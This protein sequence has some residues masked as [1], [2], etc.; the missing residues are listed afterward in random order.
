MTVRQAWRWLGSRPVSFAVMGAWALLLLMWLA[1]FE[2]SG[3][4]ETQIEAI[5]TEWLPFRVA[6]AALLL[7]TLACTVERIRR[8]V[9]R[10][11]RPVP[12]A[13]ALERRTPLGHIVGEDLVR[14]AGRLSQAGYRVKVA[15]HALVGVL[16]SWAPLGGSALHVALL[17]AAVGIGLHAW[18]A[19]EVDF[20]AIEG[21][22]LAP[23]V[24]TPV[25]ETQLRK[26]VADARLGTI[27]PA[28]YEDVLL[29][30]SLE[31]TLERADGRADDLSLARPLWLDPF[32]YLSVVD[33]GY[34][35]HFTVV[36]E[37]GEVLDDVV[38]AMSLFPPGNADRASLSGSRL[39]LD[40]VVYPDYAQLAGRDV[41]LSYNKANPRVLINALSEGTSVALGGRALLEVGEPFEL[42]TSVGRATITV[43]EVRNY[44]TFRISR[45]YGMPVLVL[46]GI[47]AVVGLG[48]R[49]YG[50]RVDVVVW[51]QDGGLVYDAHVD[52]E[53]R[54]SARAVVEALWAEHRTRGGA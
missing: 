31:A 6:Y 5:A 50:R 32:T 43:A 16:R 26:T 1:P 41:S 30:T 2:L 22:S 19:A 39:L 14:V 37:S 34:A 21:E 18:T 20:R 46:A 17:L 25:E 42:E 11:E 4:P 28:Y 53:G 51:Q 38:T 24:G 45:S 29:F 33:Y 8:D 15:D 35:P 27:T 44:G 49:V 3:L 7:V 52:T 9:R 47:L 12:S 13:D 48:V 10:L 36:R 40:V 23:L 54:Q